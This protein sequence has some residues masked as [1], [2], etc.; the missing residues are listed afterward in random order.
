MLRKVESFL[1]CGMKDFFL[2]T[3][4]TRPEYLII[5]SKYFWSEIKEFYNIDD[6]IA[7]Y[8]CVYI[9]ISKFMYILNQASMVAYR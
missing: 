1:S 6:L 2:E 3:P 7:N 4:M 5:H 9:N 8:G